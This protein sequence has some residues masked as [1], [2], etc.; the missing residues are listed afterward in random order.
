MCDTLLMELHQ[1]HA[2]IACFMHGKN[3]YPWGQI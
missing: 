2:A 3:R 1:K